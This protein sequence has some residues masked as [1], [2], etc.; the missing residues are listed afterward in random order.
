MFTDAK[1]LTFTFAKLVFS[2]YSAMK[3]YNNAIREMYS[4]IKNQY[5]LNKKVGKIY[6][7]W[8]TQGNMIVVIVIYMNL[9]FIQHYDLFMKQ[10]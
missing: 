4:K 1:V 2:S 7:E 5:K 8:F 3:D 10:I 9:M 6:H